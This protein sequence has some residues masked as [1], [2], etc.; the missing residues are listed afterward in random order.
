MPTGV[1]TFFRPSQLSRKTISA[2]QEDH[3]SFPGTT[4]LEPGR[5]IYKQMPQI[6]VRTGRGEAG[7]S[8]L[9]S[10]ELDP[11]NLI[12][13]VTQIV[14]GTALWWRGGTEVPTG[15]DPILFFVDAPQP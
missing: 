5:F 1:N 4:E 8:G 11:R 3:L 9:P 14:V 6:V 10:G 15:S 7:A 13:Y 12:I 2:F